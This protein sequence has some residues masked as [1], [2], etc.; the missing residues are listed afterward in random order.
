VQAAFFT[1]PGEA[2]MSE[3]TKPREL[4]DKLG[5]ITEEDFAALLGSA[6]SRLKNRP[7]AELPSFVKL[8]HRRL[9]K[10]DSVR[11]FLEARTVKASA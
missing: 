10:E 6:M 7:C 8:G 5:L 1:F 2:F 3:R 9:F 4:L 11:A